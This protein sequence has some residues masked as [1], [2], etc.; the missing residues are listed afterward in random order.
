M[1]PMKPGYLKREKERQAKVKLRRMARS[2]PDNATLI[3]IILAFPE[4]PF[5]KDFYRRIVKDLRFTPVSLEVIEN[6]ASC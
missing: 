2:I 5:R 4:R 6:V 3:R 1:K